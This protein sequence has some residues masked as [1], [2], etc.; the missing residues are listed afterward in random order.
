MARKRVSSGIAGVDEILHGGFFTSSSYLIVGSAGTGKTVMSMQWL[1]AGVEAGERTLFVTLAEPAHKIRQN[2]ESFGWPID[3][4]EIVDLTYVDESSGPGEGEYEIFPASDVERI[5]TWQN[6]FRVIEERRP[7]RIVIDSLTQLRYLSVDDYQFRKHLMRLVNFLDH[8]GCT[9]L[10]AYEPVELEH[11]AS[12]ALAVDGIIRLRMQVSQNRVIGLRSMQVE[13]LRGSDFISGLH[14][15]RITATGMT[16]FPHRIELIDRTPPSEDV[17]STGVTELDELLAGGIETGTTSMLTGPPGVGKSTLSMRFVA[18][19]AERGYRGVIYAFEESIDSI[20]RRSRNVGIDVEPL[21]ADGRMRIVPV[22]ALQLYPDEFL[23]MVRRDVD[24]GASVVSVD[25]LR[26]YTL[27]MEEF[28]TPVAHLHNLVTH[29]NRRGVT[30]MLLNEVEFITGDLRAT[31]LGVSHVADNIVLMRYAE[32]RSSVIKV[33]G[34][35]K[36]RLGGF[37]PELRELKISSDGI[38]VSGKLSFLRGI[39]SGIPAFS[40]GADGEATER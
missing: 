8:C 28:G 9:A 18:T 35:L 29:L 16:V 32:Y 15:F 36:K 4:I 17:L 3:R 6:L 2:V 19:A 24:L 5:P 13:K 39:L 21:L 40:I 30:T 25:S 12:V 10:L 27:A 7:S 31:D 14:P 26:G 1:A 38:H 37:Q 33:I 23:S 22:N 11:E 20:L 34:C